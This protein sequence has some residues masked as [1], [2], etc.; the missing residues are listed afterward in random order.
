MAG[1]DQSLLLHHMAFYGLA[2]ILD[3]SG[4]GD[5]AV[6]WNGPQPV[7]SGE[8]LDDTVVEEAVRT[9]IEGRK[10]WT[11]NSF[12]TER[13][14]TMSPRLTVFKAGEWE[15]HQ[16]RREEVLTEL[17]DGRLWPDLRYLAAL[18]E[19]SYWSFNF[20]GDRLQDNGASRFEMQPRNRGSEFVGNRLRPLTEKLLRR[21][22]GTI[23][24]GLSG[25]TLIDELDG[26]PNSVT[27]TGL[28]MPGPADNAIVWCALWGIGQFPATYRIQG[29]ALTSGYI[30]RNRHEWFCVPVWTGRWR[31]ARLRSIL[32]SS[33]L[34]TAAATGLA[35]FSDDADQEMRAG[36]WLRSRGV[37]G[38]LRF[39]IARFGSDNAP[40]RRALRAEA[41]PL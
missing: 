20:R 17:T 6:E 22:P 32:A 26:K 31:P 10:P 23:A 4:I 3:T 41:I 14:A 39:P 30:G 1:A 25:Q 8:N 35:D 11:L 27:A 7:L 18:G 9:H 24:S 33:Q 13:R 19:P 15:P 28:A 2:D 5:L 40:E 36:S 37:I 21:R 16:R 29:A 12:G 38:V 34:R